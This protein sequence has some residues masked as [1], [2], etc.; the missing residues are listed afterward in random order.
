MPKEKKTP[1]IGL[2]VSKKTFAVGQP[3][4]FELKNNG[5]QSVWFLPSIFSS[6]EFVGAVFQK[7][8][9][10]FTAVNSF[11]EG[12]S[13]ISKAEVVEPKPFE[14]KPKAVCKAK[15]SGVVFHIFCG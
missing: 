8:A 6:L 10:T 9:S 14:L 1:A 12:A 11:N 3:I 2:T 7:K 4:E 15:W 13:I 5:S